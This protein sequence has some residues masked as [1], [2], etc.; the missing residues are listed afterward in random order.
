MEAECKTCLC[1]T[2]FQ[3]R[4]TEPKGNQSTDLNYD[5]SFSLSSFTSSSIPS[6]PPQLR[7][8]PRMQQLLCL[9]FP[10]NQF[11]LWIRYH[12][13]QQICRSH[14]KISSSCSGSSFRLVVVALSLP[15]A[16][17]LVTLVSMSAEHSR[18]SSFM[19]LSDCQSPWLFVSTFI[20]C[21]RYASG[22]CQ[23]FD[24]SG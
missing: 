23:R 4:L 1:T 11:L 5:I 15:V 16:M 21:F 24:T 22:Q 7:Y 8:S 18:A 12:C 9:S 6:V 13:T 19:F 20:L 14:L 17:I 10:H 2:Q 3:Y